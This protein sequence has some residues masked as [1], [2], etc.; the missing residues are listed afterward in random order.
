MILTAGHCARRY[1]SAAYD[2]GASMLPNYEKLNASFSKAVR[3]FLFLRS[4]E[5]GFLKQIRPHAIHE[6]RN[7]AI[8]RPDET[9]DPTELKKSEASLLMTYEEIEDVD[10]LAIMNK[11]SEMAAQFRDQNAKHIFE[12][13]ND[14]TTKTGQ[15]VNAAGR[16]LT[17]DDLIHMMERIQLDF[18]R[19]Q[20]AGDAS[21]VVHPDMVPVLKRLEGE[22]NR[23]VDLKKRWKE[24][25]EKKKDEYRQRE[26]DRNLAG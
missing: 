9:V 4:R 24:V 16:P 5:D 14:V 8:V 25:M 18:E 2:S 11:M 19:N 13:L 21:L 1:S 6:G 12:T 17:N 20:E 15:V 22:M 7:A 10:L 23:S 26:A 3:R